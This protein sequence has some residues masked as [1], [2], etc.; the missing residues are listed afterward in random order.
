MI[1]S[2]RGIIEWAVA[3]GQLPASSLTVARPPYGFTRPGNPPTQA[4]LDERYPH[5]EGTTEHTSYGSIFISVLSFGDFG[6]YVIE[7]GIGNFSR[8]PLDKPLPVSKPAPAP[9]FLVTRWRK[10]KQTLSAEL[11][12]RATALFEGEEQPSQFS[13][14][15]LQFESEL[16][17]MQKDLFKDSWQRPAWSRPDPHYPSE[18]AQR[19]VYQRT[20]TLG[21][22]PQLFGHFDR[23]VNYNDAGRD[24]HKRERFGK[25]YQWIAYHELLARVA[26]N[27]HFALYY[28]DEGATFDG[29]YQFNDREI[30]PSLPPVPYREFQ[31]QI[32]VQGTWQPTGVIFPGLLPGSVDSDIYAGDYRTFLNDHQTLPYPGRIGRLMD[33]VGQS[34]LLLYGH[35]TQGMR[36][37]QTDVELAADR[38][39]YSLHS[40]LAPRGEAGAVAAAIPAKLKGH[41]FSS[42]LV[43]SNGHINCCYFGE[44]GW[45]EMKCPFRH[46]A[47][48]TL[49]TDNGTSLTVTPTVESYL[50]EGVTWDCSI[51]D[52][53][54]A[55][56][57]SMFL[58][59]SSDLRWRGDTTSWHDGDELVMCYMD[60]TTTDSRGDM[61]VV[62]EEWLE[63][64]LAD[65]EMALVYCVQGQRE[66]QDGHRDFFWIEFELSGSYHNGDLSPG[67]SQIAARSNTGDSGSRADGQE[68]S[69]ADDS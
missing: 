46:D 28:D 36:P 56:L 22:T 64:Y 23:Y 21:W 66:H 31:D 5:G 29:V 27:Y 24:A 68:A 52:S 35:V 53:V 8:V 15:V 57:P 51:E 10:F 34:W 45:R 19:W 61:L 58:Q 14:D 42:D 16:S 69:N 50:W 40:W 65:R 33:S 9:R 3:R 63:R 25:K 26:D 17:D 30:D 41:S 47:P 55:V 60:M 43:D 67:E 32:V 18:R 44:L 49:V 7:S 54:K 4:H 37:E 1:D 39:F 38:Q 11:A 2:A 13:P 6:R 20:M 12:A 48:S 59:E 62:K